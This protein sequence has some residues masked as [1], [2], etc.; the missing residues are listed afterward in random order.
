[1]L[2]IIKRYN[3]KACG[4]IGV[5]IQFFLNSAVDRGEISSIG[6][7]SFHPVENSPY[8]HC[9]GCRVDF[10]TGVDKKS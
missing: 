10:R 3:M 2:K 4:E 9:I 6:V 8:T 7:G 1:V 5:Y